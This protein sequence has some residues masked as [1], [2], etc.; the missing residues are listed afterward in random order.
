MKSTISALRNKCFCMALA[1]AL[2][3]VLLVGCNASP[4]AASVSLEQR[5]ADSEVQSAPLPPYHT[6]QSVPQLPAAESDTAASDSVSFSYF[7]PGAF[8]EGTPEGVY[9]ELY[10]DRTGL[11]TADGS[12]VA[13]PVVW[14]YDGESVILNFDGQDE[15]SPYLVSLRAKEENSLT[16]THD[17]REITLHRC[18]LSGETISSEQSDAQTAQS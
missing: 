6:V 10:D 14:H 16:L 9:L 5:P 15:N 11:Y 4:P 18:T 1:A 12:S 13:R 2:T 3:A 8:S 17:K 7:E